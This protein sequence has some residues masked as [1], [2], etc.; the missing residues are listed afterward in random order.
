MGTGYFGK[1]HL[2]KIR[3]GYRNIIIPQRAVYFY[4]THGTAPFDDDF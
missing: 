4:K 2:E 1:R 3:S